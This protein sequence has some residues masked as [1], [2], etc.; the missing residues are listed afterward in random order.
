MSAQYAGS[1]LGLGH[2]VPTAAGSA[3]WR[4]TGG[5][6]APDGFELAGRRIPRARARALIY[7]MRALY[8]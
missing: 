6:R 2:R 4:A 7:N 1:R 5:F 3:P 8:F